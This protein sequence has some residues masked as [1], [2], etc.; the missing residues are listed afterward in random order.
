MKVNNALVTWNDLISMQISPKGIAPEGQQIASKEAIIVNYYVNEAAVPFAG[1][2][3]NRLP[4]YQTIISLD[5]RMIGIAVEGAP[6][7]QTGYVIQ[8]CSSGSTGYVSFGNTTYRPTKNV[9]IS[10]TLFTG[11]WQI[12]GPTSEPIQTFDVAIDGEYDTCVEC[13]NSF[14]LAVTASAG[15]INGVGSVT[16]SS[17]R[18][19]VAP[20]MYVAI[21]PNPASVAADLIDQKTA[22]NGATSYTWNNLLDGTWFVGVADSQGTRAQDGI[23]LICGNFTPPNFTDISI[24]TVAVNRGSGQYQIAGQCN[25]KSAAYPNWIKGFFYTSN[26]YGVTWKQRINVVGWWSVSGIS[27]DGRYMLIAES[28]GVMYKSS[29]YGVTWIKINYPI[30]FYYPDPY[31]SGQTVTINVGSG[32]APDPVAA[33]FF[34]QYFAVA[35]SGNGQFQFISGKFA[36]YLANGSKQI[37]NA[38]IRSNDYGVTWAIMRQDHADPDQLFSPD[39]FRGMDVTSDGQT[40]VVGRTDYNYSV[41]RSTNAGV[42]WAQVTTGYNN[43]GIIAISTVPDGSKMIY[44]SL[45]G[46]NLPYP[47][48][49]N[50]A[51]LQKSTNQGA[52][53]VYITNEATPQPVA[54]D[55]WYDAVVVSGGG[56]GAFAITSRN[57]YIKSIPSLDTILDI[58]SSGQKNWRAIAAADNGV[59]VLAGSNLGLWRSADQ[60]V[61][62]TRL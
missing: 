62:W 17:F 43:G 23:S 19:G 41:L 21:G 37:E 49:G 2:A 39:G 36:Y 44:S 11:C 59:Y 38:I 16:A 32:P 15:C 61:T 8:N 5:C 60:G 52:T 22:L 29:D 18:G 50:K 3:P 35:I 54:A 13:Q 58:T 6:P 57:D 46:S 27:D 24:G 48:S 34:N 10:N 53:W 45:G 30:S 7:P 4:P 42:N 26:D 51:Y 20:Y 33:N 25:T 31:P 12:I 1:Y 14:P 55:S 9:F 40:V 28:Y 56:R 47:Y